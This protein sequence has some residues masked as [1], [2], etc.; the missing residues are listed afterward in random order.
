VETDTGS[1]FGCAR[2]FDWDAAH[3][4]PSHKGKCSAIHGHRYRAEVLVT[5]SSLDAAGMVVDFGHL[6]YEIGN[7]IDEHWDHNILL[8]EGESARLMSAVHELHDQ[9]GRPAPYVMTQPPTA[10][11]ISAELAMVAGR[12]LVALASRPLKVSSVTVWETPNCF[13]RWIDV[14]E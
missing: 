3:R 14:A 13:G 9:A 5:A 1:V 8:Y 2:Y 6:K 12:V 11:A 10:E 4:L 7:W